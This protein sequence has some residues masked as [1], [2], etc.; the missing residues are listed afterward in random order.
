MA[1]SGTPAKDFLETDY[2]LQQIE[3]AKQH[4]TRQIERTIDQN[5]V[6]ALRHLPQMMF[7]SPLEV[8][9]WIWW[10]TVETLDWRAIHLVCRRQQETVIDGQRYRVDFAIEPDD[11]SIAA[12]KAW[13][14]IAVEVDGH[15]FHERTLEQVTYRNQRDRALQQAGW[16]VFHFSFSEFTGDPLGAVYEVLE[17]ALKQHTHVS[18]AHITE[19]HAGRRSAQ[20]E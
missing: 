6:G 7:D 13:V 1:Y 19:Q 12:H 10:H 18:I 8:A 17:F 16:K 4:A 5:I 20:Q 3:A 15:G 2:V 9:F 11:P 14:P